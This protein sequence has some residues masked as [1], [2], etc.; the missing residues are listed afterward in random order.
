M[1]ISY[2][3]AALL[4]KEENSS[5]KE[6]IVETDS[7]RMVIGN[8]LSIDVCDY[9]TIYEFL[10]FSEDEII[11]EGYVKYFAEFHD[12]EV[13]LKGDRKV[14]FRSKRKRNLPRDGKSVFF[15]W[16]MF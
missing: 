6:I 5:R 11:L 13:V 3:M 7:L 9:F 16:I 4:L 10:K 14:L 15:A 8:I 12:L 1:E 2:K